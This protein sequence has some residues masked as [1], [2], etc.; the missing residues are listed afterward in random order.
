MLKSANLG[1]R[2]ILEI[3]AL[4]A[5]GYWGFSTGKGWLLKALLGVGA[6][7]VAAVLWANFGAPAAAHRLNMPLR[8]VLELIIF[9]SA[10]AGLNLA[11]QKPLGIAFGAVF[12]VNEILLLLWKQ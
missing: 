11:D 3:L 8:F 1:V 5:L 7:L 12:V 9:G 10:T 4:V 6:P 2:F